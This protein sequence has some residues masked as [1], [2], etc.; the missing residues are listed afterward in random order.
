MRNHGARWTLHRRGRV[1]HASRSG[2]LRQQHDL[3]RV[4]AEDD[5]VASNMHS[6]RRPGRSTRLSP[7]GGDGRNA[8]ATGSRMK[9]IFARVVSIAVD[10]MT[11]A[12]LSV[13]PLPRPLWLSTVSRGPKNPVKAPVDRFVRNLV[14]CSNLT[15]ISV[16]VSR[17]SLVR[18][19]AQNSDFTARSR[20]LGPRGA[21]YSKDCRQAFGLPYSAS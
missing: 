3:P 18:E 9:S 14:R 20:C 5:D 4:S 1:E 7:G 8:T 6:L 15:D 2:G 13:S 12:I 11:A 17:D 16:R 21:V 19:T 10:V